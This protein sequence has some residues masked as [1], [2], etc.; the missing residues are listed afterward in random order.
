MAP[1]WRVLLIGLGET[2][3]SALNSLA[4]SLQVVGV[5]RPVAA[6]ATGADAV[7]AR[8]AD[9][10][11]PAY[12][13]ASPAAISQ[14]VLDLR[15]DCV[16][17]SSYDRIIGPDLLRRVPFVNVHY[18]PLPEYRGRA[19]V[20]WAIIN[21]EAHTALSIHVIAPE[22]DAGN[23]LF[24][25]TVPILP[26]D[27]VGTLYAKLNALQH[28]HLAAAVER[29]L[30]GD[31]GTP[32]PED[33]ASYGCTRLPADGHIDWSAPTGTIARLIRALDR[34]FPG[35]YTYL[36]ERKLVIWRAKAVEKPRN[37]AGRIAGRVVSTS[38]SEGHVD[39]LTGDGVLRLMEVQ[40]EGDEP[41]PASAVIKSV[42]V[43]LGLS[44]ESLLTRVRQ[45][46]ERLRSDGPNRQP[47]DKGSG[48]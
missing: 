48:R 37:Y 3:L 8:A 39:V 21:D 31:P 35:A 34:P 24:Q 19:N 10:G 5:V 22:L 32:Q 30:A 7:L 41:T 28:Q 9:L 12:G 29:F 42:R 27:T 47:A 36:G 38:G 20:N 40:L 26:D 23:L 13:D 2:A 11:V 16:V 46:E 18:S 17:V 25:E 44:A 33:R 1:R 45:L 4:E 6:G 14:T 15:P 43:S